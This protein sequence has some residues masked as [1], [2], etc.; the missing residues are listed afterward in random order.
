MNY[1]NIYEKLQP[2]FMMED[3]FKVKDIEYEAS[4]EIFLITK[5]NFSEQNEEDEFEN[6]NFRVDYNLKKE[7]N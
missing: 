3:K 4:L 1:L 7:N 2:I 5:T 6:L